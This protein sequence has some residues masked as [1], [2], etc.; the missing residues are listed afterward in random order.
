MHKQITAGRAV[1]VAG[2]ML[3][4]IFTG[5]AET[6]DAKPA[7]PLFA[8]SAMIHLTIKAPLDA[9]QQDLA[10]PGNTV[11]GT[12]SVTGGGGPETLP[13]KLS[14]RG[15]T[16]R[17]PDVCPFPPLRVA[18]DEKPPAGSLFKG[19]K[20]LKLVTHCQ[21]TTGFQQYLLLEY[22]AYR[23]YNVLTPASFAVRLATIDYVDNAGHPITS[24]LGFFIESLGGMAKRNDLPEFKK[25]G[26]VSAAEINA[27]DSVRFALFQDMI[28]NL[29]WS[30]TANVA[31]SDCCHNARLLGAEGATGNLI[32]V[33]YDF[34]YSGLVDTP[35]AVPPTAFNASSVRVRYYN[36]F[37]HA[38]AQIPV[39]AAEFLAKRAELFAVL[40]AIPQ[41][42]SGKRRK[43][44]DYLGS[45]FEQNATPES[46]DTKLRKN[47]G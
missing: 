25:S 5:A 13:I 33:P 24:R 17:R 30:M 6:A 31:D 45:F 10:N 12:L 47:C 19:Q 34:D 43:A 39:V 38:N 44:V 7:E 36:G 1:I 28:G 4:A 42:D 2:F 8:S 11:A 27:H 20:N 22:A 9:L 32:P 15:L 21:P 29:D 37:C 16:R 23:M 46:I 26:T 35:Y 40:D 18:F 14:L 3:A 41:L